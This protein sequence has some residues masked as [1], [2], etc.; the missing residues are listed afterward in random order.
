MLSAHFLLR[1]SK[2]FSLMFFFLEIYAYISLYV[3][4]ITLNIISSD[5]DLGSFLFFILTKTNIV[6]QLWYYLCSCFFSREQATPFLT[7]KLIEMCTM[8]QC[9]GALWHFTVVA[10]EKMIKPECCGRHYRSWV[11][12]LDLGLFY[13]AVVDIPRSTMTRDSI[14]EVLEVAHTISS[15]TL[16]L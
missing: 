4:S 7:N 12:I 1:I 10:F 8:Q 11:R 5:C 13:V 6:L 15:T 3:L 14:F 9:S 16:L 2:P